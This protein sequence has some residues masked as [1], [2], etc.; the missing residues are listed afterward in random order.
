MGS[1]VLNLS[2]DRIKIALDIFYDDCV[3]YGE[4]QNI[5]LAS[6]INTDEL[7]DAIDRA[8]ANYRKYSDEFG[9]TIQNECI[10]KVL[11]WSAYF[12]A[13]AFVGVNKRMQAYSV[14]LVAADRMKFYLD[15]NNKNI[16]SDSI[17]K[18][19]DMVMCEL[20]DNPEIGL[21]C[22]GFYMVFRT[23]AYNNNV[24]PGR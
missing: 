8:F 9:I 4:Q 18:A 22:N 15:L 7:V 6:Y 17:Q 16:N 3:A 11:S 10:Y 24:K 14:L 19:I 23:I 12:L 13:K 21:G 5:K 1:V 20:T 2:A